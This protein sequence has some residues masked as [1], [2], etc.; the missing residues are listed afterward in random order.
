MTEYFPKFVDGSPET[1]DDV[2]GSDFINIVWALAG[3]RRTIQAQVVI[4]GS[5]RCFASN[6]AWFLTGKMPSSMVLECDVREVYELGLRKCDLICQCLC[7]DN[8]GFLHFRV[9]LRSWMKKKLSLCHYELWELWRHAVIPIKQRRVGKIIKLCTP[10][11]HCRYT[12]TINPYACM[13]CIWNLKMLYTRIFLYI[14]WLNWAIMTIN[15]NYMIIA[16]VPLIRWCKQTGNNGNDNPWRRF[17]V[18]NV[19]IHGHILSFR[20]TEMSQVVEI[21]HRG[22]TE[23]FNLLS[24]NHGSKRCGFS[25][26]RAGYF[27][28]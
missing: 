13:G 27:C 17:I 2:K 18:G 9:Q 3:S 5:Q 24:Q 14:S 1:C 4:K 10:N 22:Q 20:N 11:M 16:A 19:Q 12:I 21:L 6:I 23:L 7:G 15:S 26:V 28:F 25:E 8:C